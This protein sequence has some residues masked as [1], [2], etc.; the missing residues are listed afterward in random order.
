MQLMPI[1]D[2]LLNLADQSDPLITANKVPIVPTS[3][4]TISPSIAS[5][6]K[7]PIFS[8]PSSSKGRSSKRKEKALKES[9]EKIK[10]PSKVD[11]LLVD[12]V[13]QDEKE[14]LQRISNEEALIMLNYIGELKKK[15]IKN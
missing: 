15:A 8:K 4:S 5:S 7:I 10:A 14:N 13:E 3:A 6:A 1:P 9:S 11:M 12:W 2:I